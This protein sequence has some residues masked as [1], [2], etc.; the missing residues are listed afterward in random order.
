MVVE[1]L[2]VLPYSNDIVSYS[3]ALELW[4]SGRNKSRKPLNPFPASNDALS[5]LLSSFYVLK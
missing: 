1:L 2:H 4:G 5:L 3:C